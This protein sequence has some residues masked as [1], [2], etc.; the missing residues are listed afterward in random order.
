ME[1]W[2]SGAGRSPAS[3]DMKER[4]VA[5]QGD[6]V[7]RRL[8]ALGR[9]VGEAQE[10][11]GHYGGNRPEQARRTPGTVTSSPLVTGSRTNDVRAD[12]EREVGMTSE[13]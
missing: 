10:G 4:G 3:T 11:R 1:A 13:H 12:A 9:A 2:Q 6:K 5:G 8:C 7:K